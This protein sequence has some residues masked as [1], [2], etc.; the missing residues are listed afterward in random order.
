MKKTLRKRRMVVKLTPHYHTQHTRTTI[1][2]YQSASISLWAHTISA[3]SLIGTSIILTT[4]RSDLLYS[5]VRTFPSV[6]NLQL[7]SPIQYANNPRCTLSPCSL[8]GIPSMVVWSR[9]RT[10][11]RVYYRHSAVHCMQTI[12]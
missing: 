11:D 12:K 1:C 9:M 10:F 4:I 8:L 3:I 6:P 7:P 2:E 5:C